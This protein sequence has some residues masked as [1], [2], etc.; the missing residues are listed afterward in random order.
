MKELV[1]LTSDNTML[2]GFTATEEVGTCEEIT[3]LP[4]EAEVG[5]VATVSALEVVTNLMY[6]TY[7][8]QHI[9][10]HV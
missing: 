4:E 3:V 8:R 6:C 5:V 2:V 10:Q 7:E 9:L 1:T